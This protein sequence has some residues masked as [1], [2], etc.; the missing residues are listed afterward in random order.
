MKHRRPSGPLA[1]QALIALDAT[2]DVEDSFALFPDQGHAVDA[3]IAL[4]EQGHIVDEAIGQRCLDR[5]QGPLTR[6]EHGEK[7]YVRRRHRCHAHQPTKHS[8]HEHAPPR[9]LQV[10]TLILPKG[11]PASEA[12]RQYSR[13]LWTYTVHMDVD[14]GPHNPLLYAFGT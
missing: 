10:H 13:R 6:A 4:V 14:N 7:L 2:G 12:P 8:G 5:P 11:W 1:F 9:V 3:A